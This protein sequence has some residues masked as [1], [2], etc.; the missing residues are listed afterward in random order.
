MTAQDL[1]RAIRE[2]AALYGA[3]VTLEL[4][5]TLIA[6]ARRKDDALPLIQHG[7]SQLWRHYAAVNPSKTVLDIQ[8]YNEKG[9][10]DRLLSEHADKVALTAAKGPTAPTAQKVIDS[11]LRALIDTN[12]RGDA[13]RRPCS[14][15]N[16][17]A[18][19]GTTEAR[20]RLVV[21]AFQ[22]PTVSFLTPLLPTQISGETVLDISHEAL[23]RCWGRIAERDNGLREM[24][25]RDGLIWRSLMVQA[26]SYLADQNNLLSEATTEV[27]SKWLVEHNEAWTR[28]YGGHYKE[29]CALIEAS[30]KEAEKQQHA[31]LRHARTQRENKVMRLATYASIAAVIAAVTAA[32]FAWSR[33]HQILL[34]NSVSWSNILNTMSASLDGIRTKA[35][36]RAA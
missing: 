25:F 27:R 36:Q 24:E 11:L 1:V 33:G 30:V 15:R 21:D 12:I 34:S 20:L 10:L 23:I 13:V 14:F 32:Y 26:E 4:A 2:P 9:P 16:L 35:N 17:L 7:L 5:E 3:H 18:A 29:V 28:R 31:R 8:Q 22:D 19:T 6:H